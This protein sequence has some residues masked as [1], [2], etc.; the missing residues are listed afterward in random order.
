MTSR[1]GL[2]EPNPIMT[3]LRL[4]DLP[5]IE[6]CVTGLADHELK[7]LAAILDNVV[8]RVRAEQDAR[9][10]GRSVHGIARLGARTSCVFCR[11]VYVV[12]VVPGHLLLNHG[13]ELR[14]WWTVQAV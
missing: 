4:A 6:D 13:Q 5:L 9:R 14:R 8:V 2:P 11:G 12:D 10:R 1:Y 3:A 7:V